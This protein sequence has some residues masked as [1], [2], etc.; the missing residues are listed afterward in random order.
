MEARKDGISNAVRSTLG[1]IPLI[2]DGDRVR[3][4]TPLECERLQ[5]FADG[6]TDVLSNTQRYRMLGNAV[7]VNVVREI[8]SHLT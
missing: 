3:K 6:W 2:L 7:T 5:A 8:V 4:A 1:G